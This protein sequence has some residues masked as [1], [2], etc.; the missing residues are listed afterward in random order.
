MLAASQSPGTGRGGRPA[1]LVTGRG[2]R[3]GCWLAASLA[4]SRGAAAPPHVRPALSQRQTHCGRRR[5]LCCPSRSQTALPGHGLGLACSRSRPRRP[6]CGASLA[7]DPSLPAGC[8]LRQARGL[9]PRPQ[10]LVLC[11]LGEASCHFHL[12][13]DVVLT[14]FP[15]PCL[16]C[17]PVPL[18][19][20]WVR[21]SFSRS[22]SRGPARGDPCLLVPALAVPHTSSQWPP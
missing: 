4:C 1:A 14:S 18:A 6:R 7:P 5:G 20:C 15:R 3:P 2:R 11:A 9:C 21:L 12:R 19:T 22:R 17:G 13:W 10:H 16:S 8:A